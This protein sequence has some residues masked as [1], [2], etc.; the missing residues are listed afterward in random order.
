M[1]DHAQHI[2]DGISQ[3]IQSHLNQCEMECTNPQ[4]AADKMDATI[5]FHRNMALKLR[6]IRNELEDC[7]AS[8]M[9]REY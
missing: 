4:H 2:I 9:P 5:T 7:I 3:L 8:V 6:S 1:N